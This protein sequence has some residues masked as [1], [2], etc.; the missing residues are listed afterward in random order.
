MTKRK[1]PDDRI[2]YENVYWVFKYIKNTR[3]PEI[4]ENAFYSIKT[5]IMHSDKM[6]PEVRRELI[7]YVDLLEKH[8]NQILSIYKS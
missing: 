4:A 7:D 8:L 3:S 1:F 2:K 6:P 5:T